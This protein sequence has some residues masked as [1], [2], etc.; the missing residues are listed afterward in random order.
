MTGTEAPRT[1][2][3]GT[4]FPN[5]ASNTSGIVRAELLRWLRDPVVL[6]TIAA[7]AVASGALTYLAVNVATGG[8]PSGD[9]AVRLQTDTVLDAAA[10]DE[11]LASMSRSGL[12]MLVPVAA[13]ILGAYT[14]GT[15]TASGALLNLAVAARRLRFLFVVRAVVL[16]VL[17]GAA[18]AVTGAAT[19]AASGA[20]IA[21]TPELGHLSAW[22]GAGTVL[23]GASAQ[24][25]LV[26]LIAFGLAALTRRW[27]VVVISATVYLVALEP[28]LGGLVGEAY[29]W[30]PRAATSALSAPGPDPAHV[31]PTVLCALALV[32]AAVASLRRDRATRG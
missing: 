25:V 14:A 4:V 6:C 3:P 23:A 31:V 15:E 28:V 1:D 10:T 27:V 9:G 11:Q 12:T 5:R 22:H 13:A 16:L 2:S 30:L 26:G 32:A 18:G 17:L 8:A 19:L 21:R 20:G 7:L 24:A 29:A